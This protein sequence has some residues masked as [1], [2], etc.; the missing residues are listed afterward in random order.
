MS[1]RRRTVVRGKRAD[2]KGKEGEVRGAGKNRAA[3]RVEGWHDVWRSAL[4]QLRINGLTCAVHQAHQMSFLLLGCFH[5]H[6]QSA[7]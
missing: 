3:D 2:K 4:H 5:N 6:S 1:L 7:E